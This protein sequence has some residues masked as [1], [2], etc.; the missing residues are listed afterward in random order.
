MRL[1][2]LSDLHAF[3]GTPRDVPSFLD[4][5]AAASNELTHPI[6]ALKALIKREAISADMLICGGDL[7]DKAD[8]VA[9][10]YVWTALNEIKH[11][12]G[13]SEL[14]ATAGNHDLDSRHLH[15]AYD[16]RGHLLGLNPLFPLNDYALANEF[17]ARN[18][19]ILNY[20]E[21]RLVLLNSAAYHGYQEEHEHGRVSQQTLGELAKRLGEEG[22]KTMNVLVCHHSPCIHSEHDLGSDD[23][24]E[25]GE[26]LV[27]TLGS[28][29]SG[30]WLILHGHKHHPR[31]VRAEG[32]SS[33]PIVFSLGSL[34][35][36]MYAKLAANSAN[37]FYEV[38]L[39]PSNVS[40]YGFVGRFRS[41][42]WN[43]GSGFIKGRPPGLPYEGGFGYSQAP[44]VLASE[45]GSKLKKSTMK[46]LDLAEE[47][48]QL[49]FV[50]PVD[51]K[52]LNAHLQG[53][54][55]IRVTF[56]EFGQPD[57][58]GRIP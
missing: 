26:S 36:S 53:D 2:V 28:G 49:N 8:P 18:F 57:E 13:A 5:G 48:P 38:T 51:L 12:L 45:I 42:N 23:R 39:E 58:I 25:D 21:I 27:S 47:L 31:I 29:H 32:G 43:Y 56:N 15:N 4:C 7:A 37:Q 54:P 17:W 33:A 44:E 20:G 22:R 11:G 1:A 3:T 34:C 41:W 9:L 50:S 24:M 14:L 55:K 10:N 40:K 19:V 46:F 30:P 6:G 35:A 16:A 52:S